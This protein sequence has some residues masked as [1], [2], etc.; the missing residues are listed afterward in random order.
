MRSRR[1]SGGT[2][3]SA[4][5]FHPMS[6]LP[7]RQASPLATLETRMTSSAP[8]LRRHAGLLAAALFLAT[9]L[10]MATDAGPHWG[11][12]RIVMPEQWSEFAPACSGELQSPIN[13]W[14]SSVVHARQP[15]L[16]THYAATHFEVINNGHTLQATPLPGGDNTIDLDGE[17]FTLAQFHVHTPSEH[18][19]DGHEHDMELHLVH[20]AASGRIAVL[21][22]FYDVGDSDP[23]LAE[24]FDRIPGELGQAG[25]QLT[26]QGTIDP[27]ALLP[28][29]SRVVHYTGSLTTPPCSE[30]VLWNIELEPR[31]LSRGQL[32][33]LRHVYPH[34]ARPIQSFN[35]RTLVDEPAAP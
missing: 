11:Y 12:E 27:A 4:G 7:V 6:P 13:L 2:Y 28:E 23:A 35:A 29:H 17:R 34:N 8:T 14:S 25:N 30:G 15:G 1:R 31:Q 26:L 16:A 32:D 24:L 19:V 5:L 3:D 21:A 18:H 22:V 9:P 20:V 10:A 33:A